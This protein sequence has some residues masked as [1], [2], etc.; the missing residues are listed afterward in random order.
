MHV[1]DISIIIVFLV[2]VLYIRHPANV[3]N[4]GKV[5]Q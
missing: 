1:L 5:E 3:K 4:G 2:A